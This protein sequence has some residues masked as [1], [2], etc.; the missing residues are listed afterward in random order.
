MR[1]NSIP[2]AAAMVSFET[3]QRPNDTART[4][5]SRLPSSPA[6]TGHHP[7]LRGNRTSDKSSTPTT[8]EQV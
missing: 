5:P 2:Q 3:S 8:H 7:T 4:R 6:A 1:K